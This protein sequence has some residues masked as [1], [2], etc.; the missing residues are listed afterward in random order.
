MKKATALNE[1]PPFLKGLSIVEIGILSGFTLFIGLVTGGGVSVFVTHSAMPA[2]LGVAL[3]ASAIFL[4][5]KSL[6]TPLIALRKNK[7]TGWLYQKIDVWFH[8]ER[9]IHHTGL[10]QN[11]KDKR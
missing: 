2:L 7:P 5:P 10:H 3:G 11:K 6:A 1:R 9:T 8:R 4:M